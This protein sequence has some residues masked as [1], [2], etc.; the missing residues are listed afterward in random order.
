MQDRDPWIV[1]FGFSALYASMAATT[2]QGGDASEFMTVADSWGTAHPPGYPLFSALA[3][4]S[5]HTV[6]FG[7]VAWKAS[8]VAS[9][10][11][12]G[13]LAVLFVALRLWTGRIPAAIAVAALGLSLH[14]WRYAT[15]AEVFAGG[16]LTAALLVLVCVKI[17]RGWAGP[18]AALA[19]GLARSTGIANHHTVVLMFPLGLFALLFALPR[20]VGGAAKS[21]GAGA[22]GLVP[23]FAAYLVF[24]LPSGT[25]RW[26]EIDDLGGVVHHFLRRDYGTFSLGLYEG[27][28]SWWDHPL[29]FLQQLGHEFVGL[30]ALLALLGVMAAARFVARD[31]WLALALVASFALAGPI[32]LMAFNLPARG[33]FLVIATR[34]HILPHVLMTPLIAVGAQA[35]LGWSSGRAAAPSLAFGLLILAWVHGPNAGHRGWTVLEDY[36]QNMYAVVEPDAVVIGTGDPAVFGSLYLQHVE[37]VRP[38]VVYIEPTMAGHDWYVQGLKDQHPG[39][40][41]DNTV[42]R[43]A[44]LEIIDQNLDHRPVYVMFRHYRSEHYEGRLPP[45]Y[46]VGAVLMKVGAPGQDLPPPEEVEAELRASMKRHTIRSRVDTLYRAKSTWE[47]NEYDQYGFAFDTLAKACERLGD[48]ECAGR[49]HRTAAAL[50]PYRFGPLAG[51]RR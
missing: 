22:L 19:L 3:W 49:N 5:A 28:V 7:T 26:G 8:I 13:A 31:R 38:D 46:P 20:T 51:E 41:W 27:E 14:F 34:F 42:P 9:V 15:V 2:A 23:G 24:L 45:A 37:G 17:A 32:F 48:N 50:S 29:Y 44:V 33:S 30:Y 35:V 43:D 40:R 25:W 1:F 21:L 12:A 47:Y 18:G 39:F 4:L 10:Q 36:L 6:P 11:A 16:A